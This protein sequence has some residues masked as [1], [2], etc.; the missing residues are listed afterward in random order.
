MIMIFT[1]YLLGIFME[2]GIW[3]IMILRE[4]YFLCKLYSLTLNVSDNDEIRTNFIQVYKS[5]K[6]NCLESMNSKT[7]AYKWLNEMKNQNTNSNITKSIEYFQF[8]HKLEFR[9][10]ICRLELF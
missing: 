2:L 4:W 6:R 1:A 10:K 3:W 5:L 9:L 7:S 8:V